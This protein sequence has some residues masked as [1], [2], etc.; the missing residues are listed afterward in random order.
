MLCRMK[1]INQEGAQS[2]EVM[3]WNGVW[4]PDALFGS[5]VTEDESTGASSTSSTSYT[6]KLRVSTPS[7]NPAG[8]YHIEWS[9]AWGCSNASYACNMRVQ[10]DDTDT[11]WEVNPA[12]TANGTGGRHPA[13]GQ[14]EVDLSAGAHD[15]DFDYSTENGVNTVEVADVRIKIW[16]VN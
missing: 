5:N 1:Q 7:S 8:T 11:V 4:E 13:N 6:Q 9:G 2:E 14:C 16:R 10:I 3:S 15:I 12:A